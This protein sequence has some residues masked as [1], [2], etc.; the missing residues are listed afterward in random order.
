VLLWVVLLASVLASSCGGPEAAPARDATTVHGAVLADLRRDMRTAGDPVFVWVIQQLSYVEDQVG[1]SWPPEKGAEWGWAQER[2][3]RAWLN[4][5]SSSPAPDPES[6]DAYVA[7]CAE[8][9]NDEVRSSLKGLRRETWDAFVAANR[10]PTDLSE[11][12]RFSGRVVWLSED[13]LDDLFSDGDEDEGYDRIFDRYPGSVELTQMSMPGVS[14]DGKQALLYIEGAI[15]CHAASGDYYLLAR[16]N[17]V[18]KVVD[19]FMAWI[20]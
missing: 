12:V 5:S 17:G 18:W 15:G 20:A 4:D 9:D 2:S 8:R 19:H 13:D 6:W 3:A 10:E 11:V 7:A 1:M 16:E 14:E